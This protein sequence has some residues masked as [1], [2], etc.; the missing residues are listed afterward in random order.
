MGGSR[1]DTVHPS[2]NP[3]EVADVMEVKRERSKCRNCVHFER[4][5]GGIV[6]RCRRGVRSMVSTKPEHP[7]IN[8]L[9]IPSGSPPSKGVRSTCLNP[10]HPSKKCP[11]NFWAADRGAR[12]KVLRCEQPD[13][14]PTGR[15][16]LNP[17]R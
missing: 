10:L 12:S 8:P 13:K 1:T 15:V 14:N 9:E 6:V 2:R 5:P 4:N 17:R 3:E 7:T 16:E 11:P